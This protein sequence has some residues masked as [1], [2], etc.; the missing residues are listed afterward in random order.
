MTLLKLLITVLGYV[1]DIQ[2]HPNICVRIELTQ[3]YEE[4]K[5]PVKP[6]PI[7]AWLK[8]FNL[9]IFKYPMCLE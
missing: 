5:S 1:I 2:I 4:Q 9:A 3:G 7:S 6:P 8:D